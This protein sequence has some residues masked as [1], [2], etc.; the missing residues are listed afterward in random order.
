MGILE[1][2]VGL[3]KT[4]GQKKTSKK[5][6]GGGNWFGGKDGPGGPDV[7]INTKAS[8]HPQIPR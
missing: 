1:V 3:K 7:E 2:L 6:K 4:E 8:T 5:K